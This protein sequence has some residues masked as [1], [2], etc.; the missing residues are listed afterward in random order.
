MKKLIIYV[1]LFLLS[2]TN[3]AFACTDIAI[4]G[5][6]AQI[7][8]RTFD[9]H[10]KQGFV[11]IIPR[12]TKQANWRTKYGSVVFYLGQTEYAEG[13]NEYGLSVAP[14]WMSG[15]VYPAKDARPTILSDLW[16]EYFLQN[17]KDV[18]EVIANAAKIRVIMKN[19]QG[20]NLELHLVLHDASGNE[21]ILEYIKGNLVIH[22][23]NP[24]S[25]P[26]LT[27][28]PYS[29]SLNYLQNFQGF[30]GKQPIPTGYTSPDRFVRAAYFLQQLGPQTT[31]KAAVNSAFKAL[32]YVAEPVANNYHPTQWTI[33]RDHTH[34]RFFF[35]TI[36]NPKIRIIDLNKI[37][38]NQG[39][40]IKKLEINANLAGDVGKNFT[41]S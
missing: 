18:D 3:L 12:G 39:Q 37:N 23:G 30:G 34:K 11:R 28:D 19:Y 21:A 7:S 9:W 14:L 8:G 6:D 2:I 17:Y 5:Q 22:Q 38:F 4:P 20:I 35:T 10:T 29:Q 1:A 13:M 24:L 15:T 41:V 36:D 27:N 26:V 31:T 40:P 25:I 16:D 33:V 32:A